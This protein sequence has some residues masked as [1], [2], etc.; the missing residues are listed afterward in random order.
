MIYLDNA[1]TTKPYDECNNIIKK[2]NEEC[3]FNPSAMY[4]CGFDLFREIETIKKN[5]LR[6]LGGDE[7]GKI[8]FTSGAT[9]AN[10]I[11]IFGSATKKQGTYI[12][13]AGEHPSVHNCAMEL[14]SRGYDVRFISLT[15][16]GSIDLQELEYLLKNSKPCFVSTML[17]SNE[18]GA[19]NDI[20]KIRQIIDDF[21]PECILHVDAVQAFGKH[22]FNVKALGIDMCTISAHK[23]YGPKGVGALY[24]SPRVRMKTH[25]FGGGQENGIRP[26]TY[27]LPLIKAFEVAAEK[28]ICSMLYTNDLFYSLRKEF[29]NNLETI[30]DKYKIN[31]ENGAYYILSLSFD[32]IRGETVLHMLEKEGVVIGTGSACSSNKVGNRVL[33]EMGKTK[34]EILGSI[35][36]SFGIYNTLDEIKQA[37]Q[38]ISECVLKLYQM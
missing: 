24:T 25:V 7:E 37:A 29:I 17:V 31:G 9:E 26:G 16:K 22:P 20:K 19:I 35:R 13:S 14:K 15:D 4:A 2:Y 21:A 36:I 38:K 10:N 27:N 11:A 6:F 34:G 33:Q 32:G 12:F 30:K 28:T 5:F 8:Y 23:I 3:Y 1:A 18:T